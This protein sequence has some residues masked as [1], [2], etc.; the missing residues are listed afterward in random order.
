MSGPAS[1]GST[2]TQQQQQ[3]YGSISQHQSQRMRAGLKPRTFVS[4][5]C[6]FVLRTP[7]T[8]ELICGLTGTTTTKSSA[9]HGK[10]GGRNPCPL[11]VGILFSAQVH[12]CVCRPAS[13]KYKCISR[14]IFQQG[15]ETR[16]SGDL[17]KPTIEG[18]NKQPFQV[19]VAPYEKPP[20]DHRVC[21]KYSY[22]MTCGCTTW[23]TREGCRTGEECEA[24]E[25]EKDMW[26]ST[27][28]Q[29]DGVLTATALRRIKS[30]R[31]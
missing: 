21:F 31:M 30:G 28:R 27:K 8:K 1:Y 19:V 24:V 26:K 18:P 6:S 20:G 5:N 14:T 2:A 13:L 22:P 17:P 16:S 9:L 7:S 4:L 11:A 12:L 29:R 15:P 3:Q 23:E 25:K 10:A